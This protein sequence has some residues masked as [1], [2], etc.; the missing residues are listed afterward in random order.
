MCKI[1]ES[2]VAYANAVEKRTFPRLFFNSPDFLGRGLGCVDIWAVLRVIAS[3]LK[4]ICLPGV[5]IGVARWKRQKIRISLVR[6]DFNW[7]GFSAAFHFCDIIWVL[8]RLK[9]PRRLDG[10]LNSL[11]RLNTK[12]KK[13]RNFW[14][15]VG[16]S[17]S[18]WRHQGRAPPRNNRTRKI[19]EPRKINNHYSDV[20]MRAMASEITGVST[21]GSID[22]SGADQRG[23]QSSASLTFMMGIHRWPVNSP[24]KG[25]E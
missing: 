15:F 21:V 1:S 7:W 14:L 22:C 24:L 9:S 8:Q 12:K 3:L 20:I 11:F 4:G 16:G 18:H 25:L 17:T 19:R 5:S 13:P 6:L 2:F 10:L 23:N